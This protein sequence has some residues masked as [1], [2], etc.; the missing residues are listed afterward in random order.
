MIEE[1]GRVVAKDPGLAWVETL[2]QSACDS[3]SAKSGCGHSA[4]AKLGQNAIHMQAVC[5]IDVTI[6]DQVVV[7]V[8]EEIMV[9]SSILAYLMPLLTMMVGVLLA[10][11]FWGQDLL[12]ALAGIIGLALGFVILR[13]H[14]HR[15]RH[16][17]RYQPVVLRRICG[18]PQQG[19]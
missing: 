16:D 18:G 4:L 19:L 7:G 3:C 15:N 5:E 13:W 6:G 17:E 14:F 9:K 1:T 8:P 11:S 12:T 10:D 2:R